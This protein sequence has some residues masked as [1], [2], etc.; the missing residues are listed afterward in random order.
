MVFLEKKKKKKSSGLV[1]GAFLERREVGDK[2]DVD[3]RARRHAKP[4]N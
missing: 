2:W 3:L 4:T 1:D